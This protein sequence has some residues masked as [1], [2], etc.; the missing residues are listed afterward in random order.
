MSNIANESNFAIADAVCTFIKVLQE[1]WGEEITLRELGMR[2]T[3][4]REYVAEEGRTLTNQEIAN[5][6]AIPSA[7]VGRYL[8]FCLTEKCID[9][10]IDP[11]DRRRRLLTLAPQGRIRM[12]HFLADWRHS[13][14]PKCAVAL[15]VNANN[16]PR[17]VEN[18]RHKNV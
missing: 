2:M 10:N 11:E 7:T 6:T 3:I 14:A 5:A 16:H 18:L 17:P 4:M 1:N 9:E 12:S 13:V 8:L 15:D